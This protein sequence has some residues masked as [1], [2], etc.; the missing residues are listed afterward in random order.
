MNSEDYMEQIDRGGCW[1][2][3]F[4]DQLEINPRGVFSPSLSLSHLQPPTWALYIYTHT[5]HW[6]YNRESFVL[7]DL[8]RSL[9]S[10][11]EKAKKLGA[12]SWK[13][14]EIKFQDV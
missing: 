12:H 13:G 8:S 3:L 9:L 7:L 11:R 4:S 5:V 10:N 2:L 14:F 6:E 1:E